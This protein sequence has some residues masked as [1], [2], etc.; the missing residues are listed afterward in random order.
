VVV[1]LYL[2]GPEQATLPRVMFSGIRENISPTI[3]AAATV[4][5]LI[6]VCMLLTLEWLR[7]RSEHIRTAAT[8]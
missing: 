5:I 2:A 7:R 6:S 4:L 1:T 8:V 3:A